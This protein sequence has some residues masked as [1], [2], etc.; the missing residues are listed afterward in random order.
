VGTAYSHGWAVLHPNRWDGPRARLTRTQRI[1]PDRVFHLTIRGTGPPARRQIRVEVTHRGR[2][3]AAEK[4]AIRSSVRRM[5]RLDED[6]SEFHALCLEAGGRWRPAAQGLGRL[7]RSPTVFEDVVKTICTTNVQWAGTKSMVRSLVDQLGE[8]GPLSAGGDSAA[9][10]DWPAA[11]PTVEAIARA[12]D[13]TL[14]AARLGYRAP[15]VR[16]LA[17]RVANGELDLEAWLSPDTSTE[18]L[19]RSLLAIKGI[20]PYAAATM[21]MLLGRY[22]QLAVDSVYRTFVAE[23]YFGGKRP[24]DRE[25]EQ[26]YSRWGRWKYLGYWFDLWQTSD[27]EA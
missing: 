2:L 15:Y 17:K 3:A 6:L 23:T 4:A 26:V 12:D 16:E 5:L 21:L 24:S 8:P 18:E 14:E 7:L 1:G 9:A 10:E 11:F 13:R 19:R 25:A 27:A 20:G 22:D